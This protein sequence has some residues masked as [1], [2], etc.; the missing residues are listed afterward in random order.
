MTYKNERP[1]S[2]ATGLGIF[3]DKLFLLSLLKIF[4]GKNLSRKHKI[5]TH[6]TRI[7]K[8]EYGVM[9]YTIK[10]NLQVTETTQRTQ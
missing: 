1:V 2:F 6:I 4:Q 3:P 7:Q 9:D 5:Q 10:A 8:N